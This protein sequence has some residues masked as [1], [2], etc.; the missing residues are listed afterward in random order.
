MLHCKNM[1]SVGGDLVTFFSSFKFFC[2]ILIGS[3]LASKL[4]LVHKG[5]STLPLCIPEMYC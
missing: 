5:N 1:F 4:I 3:N 2:K